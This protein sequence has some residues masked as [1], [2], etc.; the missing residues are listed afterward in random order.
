MRNLGGLG[1]V[2]IAIS[3]LAVACGESDDDGESETETGGV[4]S[5]KCYVDT[6]EPSGYCTCYG[7]EEGHGLEIVGETV[8]PDC[9]GRE[10]CWTYFADD[11]GTPA[12]S[13]GQLN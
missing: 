8:V 5:W 4:A 11:V 3:L 1:L 13:C 9:S 6:I 12:C 10:A 7:L 2:V